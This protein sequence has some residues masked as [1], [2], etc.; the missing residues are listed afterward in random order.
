MVLSPSGF[1]YIFLLTVLLN[2]SLF[3]CLWMICVASFVK[4]VEDFAHFLLGCPL[5]G[6][7]STYRFLQWI[8]VLNTSS[9]SV[10]SVA[11]F[12]ISRIFS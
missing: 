8:G 10:M 11:L 3:T 2:S 12:C 4:S 7:S 5:S 6:K 1:V 9:Q